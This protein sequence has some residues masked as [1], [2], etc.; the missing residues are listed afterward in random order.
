MRNYIFYWKIFRQHT[1]SCQKNKGK[2]AHFKIKLIE[3]TKNGKAN[4]VWEAIEISSGDIL[5][6]L[7]SDISVDPETLTDFF[8]IIESNSADFVNGTRLVY[9]MEKGSMRI[10]NKL[11]N[12]VF[13]YLIGKII[14]ENLTDS[15]CGTKVLK[16]LIKKIFWWQENF[17]LKDPFGR[18]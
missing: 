17:N 3:Q 12:R 13:Q 1:R 5:A 2:N 10:I 8:K 18:F 15:L 9:E 11:G 7:D 14:N 16:D 6:I 4:A